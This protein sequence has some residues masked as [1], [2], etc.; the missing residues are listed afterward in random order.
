MYHLKLSIRLSGSNSRMKI[1]TRL[2][3]Q[4][5]PQLRK[6][7]FLLYFLILK[8]LNPHVMA[9]DILFSKL[10]CLCTEEMCRDNKM[11]LGDILF[12]HIFCLIPSEWCCIE[13]TCSSLTWNSIC[14]FSIVSCKRSIGKKKILIS[15][16]KGQRKQKSLSEYKVNIHNYWRI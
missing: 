14:S 6:L 9:E 15:Q 12:L 4:G 5:A 2:F 7:C 8:N 16:R 1:R 13:G 11:S 3:A 10:L